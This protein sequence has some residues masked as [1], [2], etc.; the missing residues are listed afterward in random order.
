MKERKNEIGVS[1]MLK[2]EIISCVPCS[3]SKWKQF[4]LRYKKNLWNPIFLLS[5]YTSSELLFSSKQMWKKNMC[6]LHLASQMCSSLLPRT[7]LI[8][9]RSEV[10][11]LGACSR[12]TVCDNTHLFQCLSG[13]GFGLIYNLP[14]FKAW[15]RNKKWSWMWVVLFHQKEHCRC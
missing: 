14:Q 4:P 7:A 8:P 9:P 1:V 3:K 15:T 5:K 11:T 10:W 12:V 2:N 6:E 13:K